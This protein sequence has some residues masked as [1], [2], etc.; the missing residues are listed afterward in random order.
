M[1]G[2]RDDD[3][4]VEISVE[5]ARFYINRMIPCRLSEN[6]SSLAKQ[7]I[8]STSNATRGAHFRPDKV[9]LFMNRLV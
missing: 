2:R 5:S 8:K 1:G 6:S 4:D 3:T 7:K 9:I